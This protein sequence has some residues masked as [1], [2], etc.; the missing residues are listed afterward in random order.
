MADLKLCI[1]CQAWIISGC[2]STG[3]CR[4]KSPICPPVQNEVQIGRFP[5]T[6][7]TCNCCEWLAADA[8]EIGK[9]K[10]LLTKGKETK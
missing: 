4:R 5:Q 7:A 10:G 9:R 1:T 8:A 3:E 2:S 6:D